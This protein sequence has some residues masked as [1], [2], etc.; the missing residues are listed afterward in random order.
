MTT[1]VKACS[2]HRPFQPR[3]RKS[4]IAWKG[5]RIL[6]NFPGSIVGR[7]SSRLNFSTRSLEESET[8]GVN[9]L[10]CS[11]CHHTGRTAKRK[12]QIARR[13]FEFKIDSFAFWGAR[14]SILLALVL[15]R[16]RAAPQPGLL[17]WCSFAERSTPRSAWVEGDGVTMYS[18]PCHAALGAD[19]HARV[20]QSDG[21]RYHFS[22][23]SSYPPN[24]VP[25]GINPSSCQV[26][27]TQPLLLSSSLRHLCIPGG[28]RLGHQSLPMHCPGVQSSA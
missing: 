2:S 25:F 18:A 19:G 9:R 12:T 1:S 16:I 3:W 10:Y 4:L 26:R 14:M 13:I 28:R 24:T 23:G 22:N 20:L 21:V 27:Y 5:C 15:L 6:R 8:R 7:C 11:V 17:Y